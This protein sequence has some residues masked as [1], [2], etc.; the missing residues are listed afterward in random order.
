NTSNA[1][2]GVAHE[3]N[4]GTLCLD[5]IAQADPKDVGEVAYMLADGAGKG[6]RNQRA[7]SNQTLLRWRLLFLSSGEVDLQTLMATV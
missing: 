1:L 4:D 7:A 6:R 2:E 3:H 5:E